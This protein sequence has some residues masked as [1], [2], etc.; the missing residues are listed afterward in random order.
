MCDF[1]CW[2]IIQSDFHTFPQKQCKYRAL[3]ACSSPSNAQTLSLKSVIVW[4]CDSPSNQLQASLKQSMWWELAF[5]P[6]VSELVYILISKRVCYFPWYM[7]FT[8]MKSIQACVLACTS[9]AHSSAELCTN[10]SRHASK[11]FCF[12]CNVD[13]QCQKCVDGFFRY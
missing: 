12:L 6:L 4:I 3:Y 10:L 8:A 13:I 7:A 2:K 5:L 9:N 11:I 1:L